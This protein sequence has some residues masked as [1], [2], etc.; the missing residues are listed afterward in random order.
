MGLLLSK[1]VLARKNTIE[2]GGFNYPWCVTMRGRNVY[3]RRVDE[4][5]NEYGD[6]VQN[7]MENMYSSYRS[8][9]GWTFYFVIDDSKPETDKYHMAS[10]A[11]SK[12]K[13]FLLHQCLMMVIDKWIGMTYQ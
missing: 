6:G 7:H 8:G 3:I 4:N 1:N 12:N 10:I 5:G 13:L 11:V 9:Q 2:K